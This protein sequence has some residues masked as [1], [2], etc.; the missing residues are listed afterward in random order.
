MNCFKVFEFGASAF[1]EASKTDRI[2]LEFALEMLVVGCAY[3][4]LILLFREVTINLNLTI[5]ITSVVFC[6]N[7]VPTCNKLNGFI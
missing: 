6:D 5:I 2:V 4:L 3:Q 1:S 7:I